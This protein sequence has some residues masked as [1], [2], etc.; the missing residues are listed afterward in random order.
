MKVRPTF[1]P[2]EW[3][4][5]GE[6]YL[7]AAKTICDASGSAPVIAHDA[8]MASENSLKALST[9]YPI[10]THDLGEV[11]DF[12]QSNSKVTSQEISQIAPALAAV[13]GSNTYSAT[14]YPDDD[15][16]YWESRKLQE[17]RD[18][19]NGAQRIHL[20]VRGKLGL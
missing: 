1:N 3:L 6:G 2:L 14:K 8:W 19:V 7:N 5:R 4:N 17:I 11:L 9:S 15:P 20:F 18:A 13:T 12:L 10:R 16:H